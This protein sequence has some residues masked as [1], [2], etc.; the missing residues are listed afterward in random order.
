MAFDNKLELVI[1]IDPKRPNASVRSINKSLSSFE[2]QAVRSTKLASRGFGGMVVR[3]TAAVVAGQAI[4]RM[5][6]RVFRALQ[7]FTTGFLRNADAMRKA[8]E[9]IGTTTKFLSG[10]RFAAEQTGSSFEV[11]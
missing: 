3:M 9:A 8:S 11:V 4:F 6:G 5:L 1:D 10:L 2:K 7:Q